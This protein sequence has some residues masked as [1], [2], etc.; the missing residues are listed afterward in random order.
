[1]GELGG[2]GGGGE[3][4]DGERGVGNEEL[5]GVLKK[6]ERGG[7]VGEL[8]KWGGW[9]EVMMGGW[10]DGGGGGGVGWVVGGSVVVVVGVGVVGGC[11]GVK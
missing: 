7:W 5:G 3:V 4:G 1:M 8:V 10:W 11:V 6:E 2:G 9:G